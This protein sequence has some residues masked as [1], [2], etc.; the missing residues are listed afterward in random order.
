MKPV[1]AAALVLTALLTACG[2]TPASNY[3]LLTATEQI[4]T[5]TSPSVGIGPITIPQYLNRNALVYNREGNALHIA[6]YERWAEP[7]EDG[8]QRVL[9]LNLAGLLDTGSV[10]SFPWARERAP[11]YAV[12]V[13]ILSLDAGNGQATLVAEWTVQRPATGEVLQRRISRLQ[14]SLPASDTVAA[15]LP[16]TYSN[17]LLQLSELIAAQITGAAATGQD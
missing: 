10:Q 17:L 1:T 15:E 9:S 4:P 8:L 6:T 12:A 13:T 16:G 5:G 11:E 7:L 3:Y 2:S 14:Q